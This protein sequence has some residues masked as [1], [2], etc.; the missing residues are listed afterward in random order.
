MISS[1]ERLKSTQKLKQEI[2]E[3]QNQVTPLTSMYRDVLSNPLNHF[4]CSKSQNQNNSLIDL[5]GDD[6]IQ[7]P[8]GTNDAQGNSKS[9][10]N[11]QFFL[12]I[13]LNTSNRCNEYA[14][15]TRFS[16]KIVK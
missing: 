16:G 1:I 11:S 8:E 4:W 7:Q 13:Q 10:K 9:P 6:D 3:R 14:P 12:F 15:R 5:L 2:V